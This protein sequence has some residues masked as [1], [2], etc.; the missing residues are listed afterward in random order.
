[1]QDTACSHDNSI[2][3][4]FKM[5]KKE[6]MCQLFKFVA[7]SISAGVIQ[8]GLFTLLNE[9]VGWKYWPSYLIALVASVVWNFTFNRKF[10]FKSASNVPKAMT[11]VLLYYAVFTPLSTL[12][13][14]AMADAGINEYIVLAFTMIVNFVTEF[15]YQRF[16][17]FRKSINTNNRAKVC[18]KTSGEKQIN[19]A[20]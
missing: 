8:M 11:L 13:G 9:L 2:A 1:M 20:M 17:V 14:Q 6:L 10:T 12:W 4:I 16:F 3:Q 18:H 19:D 15:L 5:D 7:F